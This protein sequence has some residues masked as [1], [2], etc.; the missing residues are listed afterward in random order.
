MHCV[1]SLLGIVRSQSLDYFPVLGDDR[2]PRLRVIEMCSELLA[3]KV[4]PLIE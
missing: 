1:T 3:Q 2:S 4:A